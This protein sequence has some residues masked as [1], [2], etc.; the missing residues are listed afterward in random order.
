[1]HH[2]DAH[3]ARAWTRR[4]LLGTG[5][6]M[7]SAAMTMP[8]FL[9]RSALALPSPAGGSLPGVP[10]D[11][12]LVVIQL[13]GGNDGL[14]TVAPIG[15]D[16]YHRLRP[17]IRITPQQAIGLDRRHADIGLH[18]ALTGLKDLYDNGLLALVQG[19]GY[20]N[21]NRSH[22]KS[23]DIWQ[24]ADTSGTGDGWLGRY[25][26]AECC[27]YG[28]GESGTPPAQGGAKPAKTT[29]PPISIGA[30]APLALQG[31]ATKPVAFETPDLFR[32]TGAEIHPSLEKPYEQL[33]RR[34]P[35]PNANLSPNEAF[36]MRTALDAQVSSDQI[37]RAVEARSLVDYPN[38]SL[39]QQ[40]GM[41]AK[42]I[43]AGL[44]TRV[45]YATLGSFDTHA[46]QGGANGRH[47]NLLRQFGDAVRA[48]Y[49][50]LEKQGNAGRVLT[51]S[52]SEFGRRV[53]QNASN[54]TDHGTAAPMFLF[55]PMVH[56]GVRNAHP[57][58]SNLDGGD[59]KY[60]VDFRTV[61]AAVLE[62]WMKADSAAILERRYKP[63]PVIRDA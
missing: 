13:G 10:E 57:S 46:G 47:A 14:N 8:A 53:A 28:S 33:V 20:P 2:L 61:Y 29:Y 23:M 58:L 38:G 3:N 54:G 26:D 11:R 25:Y 62:N 40:L 15:H 50:D 30:E 48:F 17:G 49:T 27:G 45:Y 24:T 44:K 41:I 9:Q 32:W 16:E 37:R 7:A 12:I 5:L 63:A 31:R 22:F 56:A 4:E 6:I 35:D 36:L 52:F 42:M 1:M 21:P 18:P 39:A 55:G 19:V 43:R 51:M 60:T 59:L 34:E